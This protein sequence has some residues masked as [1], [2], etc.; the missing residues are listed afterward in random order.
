MEFV[1]NLSRFNCSITKCGY[2][3][4]MWKIS[5]HHSYFN[6]ICGANTSYKSFAIWQDLTSL[7]RVFSARNHYNSVLFSANC[8]DLLDLECGIGIIHV[9]SIP[10]K[11]FNKT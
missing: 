4:F 9:G 6:N 8:E 3:Q 5:H 1:V 7:T 10:V 2:K 11:I